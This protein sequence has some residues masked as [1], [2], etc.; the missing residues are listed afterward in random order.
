VNELGLKVITD[1]LLGYSSKNE[2]L[3]NSIGKEIASVVLNKNAGDAGRSL[4]EAQAERIEL[5]LTDGSSFA[6]RDDGQSCCEARYITCDDDLSEL[7]GA[8]LTSI[9][10]RSAPSL[11]D[12]EDEPHDCQFLAIMTDRGEAVFTTHVEH[13]GYYGG[14]SIIVEDL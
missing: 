7:A 6:L 5:R 3:I 14:F 11:N 4:G 13:N 8:K 9:E 12:D 10:L 1:R 2:L